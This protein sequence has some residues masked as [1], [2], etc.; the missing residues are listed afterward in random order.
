MAVVTVLNIAVH[1]NPAKLLSPF[2]FEI[3]FE[4]TSALS[5]DLEWRVIYVGSAESSDHDQELDNV[6]VGPVPVGTNKFM[7]STDAPDPSK[8]P[9]TDLLGVTVVLVTC[10]YKAQ[11]FIRVGYYVN[12]A[13]GEALPEGEEAATAIDPEK[14]FRHLLEDKPR[15]TRFPIKW[16]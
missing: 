9:A 4:C 6:L 5:D 7:L 14:I 13:Y 1:N 8:I 16:E 2:Q 15:V 10:S 3:T 12:N 11:E